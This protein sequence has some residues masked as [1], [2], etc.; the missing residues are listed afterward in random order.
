MLT[1]THA[2]PT[3]AGLLQTAQRTLDILGVDV[4]AA[5]D[6]EVLKTAGE[7][8]APLVEETEVPGAQPVGPIII[9]RTPSVKDLLG[10]AVIV[11]VTGGKPRSGKPDL[12][13]ASLLQGLPRGWINDA[14]SRVESIC[15]QS[16]KLATRIICPDD[17][18]SAP[19]QGCG[20]EAGDGLRR[21]LRAEPWGGADSELG[22]CQ[23]VGGSHGAPIHAK[24]D[25]HTTEEG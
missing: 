8:E 4:L 23:P 24:A 6:D 19:P 22:L 14:D 9:A 2:Q 18:R 12:A 25:G 16:D 20:I 13:D 5:P 10:G 11:P 17:N 3:R 7:I 1:L 21:R 15:S